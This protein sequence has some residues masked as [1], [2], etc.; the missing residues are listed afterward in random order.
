[1]G[2]CACSKSAGPTIKK[3]SKKYKQTSKTPDDSNQEDEDTNASLNNEAA[4]T[5]YNNPSFEKKSLLSSCRKFFNKDTKNKL[6]KSNDNITSQ[7]EEFSP[8][9]IV[10][11]DASPY[12]KL[13]TNQTNPALAQNIYSFLQLPL[14]TQYLLNS[15]QEFDNFNPVVDLKHSIKTREIKVYIT[16]PPP[17]SIHSTSCDYSSIFNGRNDSN[18]NNTDKSLYN[19]LESYCS[20]KTTPKESS[21]SIASSLG[22]RFDLSIVDLNCANSSESRLKSKYFRRIL[23]KKV[24]NEL[25]N[26]DANPVCRLTSNS[27]FVILLTN[28]NFESEGE[29]VHNLLLPQSIDLGD[30]RKNIES[31][32]KSSDLDIFNKWYT[33]NS[34]NT[35]YE[36]RINFLNDQNAAYETELELELKKLLDAFILSFTDPLRLQYIKSI[37]QE[38]IELILNH[39]VDPT[40]II[41]CHIQNVCPNEEENDESSE[42]LMSIVKQL[43]RQR[44]AKILDLLESQV[45]LP[46]FKNLELDNSTLK[47]DSKE[48]IQ[49]MNDFLSDSIKSLLDSFTSEF[50]SQPTPVVTAESA[51]RMDKYL[52]SE[53]FKHY[54][55][56][57]SL[58]NTD[59][60]FEKKYENDFNNY[61]NQEDENSIRP[62]IFYSTDHE[63][64]ENKIS[65]NTSLFVSSLIEGLIKKKAN[66]S[67]IYRFCGCT[68]LSSEITTLLQS[69]T[70]QLSY[71]V[72]IH[73]S[74]SFNSPQKLAD[75]FAQLLS[76]YKTK[77]PKEKLVIILDKLDS[78]IKNW[79]DLET[80]LHFL[81]TI[82]KTNTANSQNNRFKIIVTFSSSL[83]SSNKGTLNI[84]KPIETIFSNKNSIRLSLTG[85]VDQV[86]KRSSVSSASSPKPLNENVKRLLFNNTEEAITIFDIL[87]LL[88]N[89]TRYGLK[90][91]E[92]R[93]II[94]SHFSQNIKNPQLLNYFISMTWYTLKY[95]ISLFN[96]P[97]SF[98]LLVASI[99][100]NQ[101]LFKLNQ[102]PGVSLNANLQTKVNTLLYT[103][104][105]TGFKQNGDESLRAFYELPKH[106]MTAT[107]KDSEEKFLNQFI[108][109]SKWLQS[110]ALGCKSVLYVMHD[111]EMYKKMFMKSLNPEDNANQET[112]S[113]NHEFRS[114]EKLL[115]K[116]LYQLY[117]NP[118]DINSIL[119]R[120][121]A[122]T[123]SKS[124][125]KLFEHLKR[126]LEKEEKAA[127]FPAFVC[128]NSQ[129]AIECSSNADP[130]KYCDDSPDKMFFSKVVFLGRLTLLTMSQ[131]RKEIKIWKINAKTFS[132]K[133]VRSMKFSK[134]PRDLRLLNNSLAAVLIERNLHLIDLNKCEHFFDMNST[135]NPNKPLFEVHD[136]QHVVL[137][138]RNRLSITLMKVALPTSN[139]TG[140]GEVKKASA[141][142]DDMFLFKV[143]ED[144]YLNSLMVSRNGQWMVCGDEVQKPFPLLVWNLVERK[145]VFDLRQAK[146]E[147]ITS[148]QSIGSSG[149]FL[150]CAC[151]EE[152][153]TKNCLIVYD[154][155]TGQL[156]KKL[157]SKVNYVNVELSEESNVIIACLENAQIVVYDLDSG[158]K[159]FTINSNH[160][161]IDNIKF[162]D[163]GHPSLKNYFI[164][165]DTKGYDLTIKLWDLSRGNTMISSFI[166]PSRIVSCSINVAPLYFNHSDQNEQSLLLAI[167]LYG[168][169]ELLIV[170]LVTSVSQS[171]QQSSYE[172]TSDEELFNE[173]DEIHNEIKLK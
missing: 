155:S 52:A 120:E 121:L 137:L 13:T 88:L 74:C 65:N 2:G 61:L 107:Q 154:L 5:T 173:A 58:K 73:E 49:V 134:V 57:L 164:T 1:M 24:L 129:I 98:S 19:H 162:L 35:A 150:V 146:H 34:S 23:G 100:E 50:G 15:K 160:Y 156:C 157:K 153:E 37:Q 85:V 22:D 29:E 26:L 144:R 84:L 42:N 78:I 102:N 63:K 83:S 171:L 46:N 28:A 92:L 89:Q 25:L 80:L 116:N 7:G 118:N 72:E 105:Q 6:K 64:N 69:I 114:I 165:Y 55:V 41:W 124:S 143:G 113:E 149:K 10:T 128:L 30:F 17:P 56:Y 21:A 20:R 161:P 111:V 109:N 159:K 108:K 125:I 101:I 87:L 39:V 103:Y 126:Q 8:P 47:N 70:Q 54:E 167:A 38:E 16:E 14:K 11:I 81:K 132:C 147:F 77:N 71:L 76:I 96:L 136:L 133:L 94:R 142:T 82:Y 106:L 168:V 45:L 91:T 151:Q 59:K 44:Y 86:V 18:Y 3:N 12:P 95:Y 97:T 53:I 141:S 4:T 43:N 51:F 112:S 90:E 93:D 79:H 166:C 170:K 135:M 32:L 172:E 9:P 140:D 158:S 31:A 130:L 62:I 131:L 163:S 40:S 152:G 67:I 127:E 145:L 110:K 68:V 122:M 75:V 27:I 119:K 99:E 123:K 104:F 36:L 138:A 169:D 148:I 66:V 48:K 139:E 33:L 115:Y 60:V 117:Q